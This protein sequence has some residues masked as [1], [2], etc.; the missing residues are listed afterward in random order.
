MRSY[1]C[2]VYVIA[3]SVEKQSSGI[4]LEYISVISVAKAWTWIVEGDSI[5]ASHYLTVVRSTRYRLLLDS[6][7]SGEIRNVEELCPG[8]PLH[9][10]LE[11]WG[12]DIPS[13]Y[14]NL[15]Q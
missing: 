7:L 3:L 12:Q 9:I 1:A 10:I 4:V 6:E 13:G 11:R 14:R 8:N 2:E 5:S 15:D